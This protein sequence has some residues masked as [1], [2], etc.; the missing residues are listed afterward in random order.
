MDFG[1]WTLG[2]G[3]ELGLTSRLDFDPQ[4]YRTGQSMTSTGRSMESA[5]S[6]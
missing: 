6:F 4:L 3:L 1:L 2:F 5:S